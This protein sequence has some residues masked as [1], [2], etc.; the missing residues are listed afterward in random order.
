MRYDDPNRPCPGAH[1]CADHEPRV[2]SNASG[3]AAQD[4]F[5]TCYRRPRVPGMR[6]TMP[7]AEADRIEESYQTY[8]PLMGGHDY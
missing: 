6:D 2:M 5:T 8:A 1:A 3:N 7:V 4:G